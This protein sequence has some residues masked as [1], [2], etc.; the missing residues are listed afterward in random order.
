MNKRIQVPVLIGV[1]ANGKYVVRAMWKDF[2][3]GEGWAVQETIGSMISELAELEEPAPAVVYRVEL[4]LLVPEPT[5]PPIH[6]VEPKDVGLLSAEALKGWSDALA[7]EMAA[8]VALSE[9][10]AAEDELALASA[11]D[12]YATR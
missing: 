10:A 5:V 8:E 3:D 6:L 12:E 1:N 11:E 7:A 4:D 9:L 2:D